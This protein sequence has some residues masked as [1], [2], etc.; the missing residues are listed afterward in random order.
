MRS[1]LRSVAAQ[2]AL[3]LWLP[4]VLLALHRTLL[5]E[6][7]EE[8]G[9]FDFTPPAKPPPRGL[10]VHE[11]EFLQDVEEEIRRCSRLARIRLR[12]ARSLGVFALVSTATIPITVAANLPGWIA[13]AL[14]SAATVAQGVQQIRSDQ[15][16]AVESHLL[17]VDLNRAARKY[18]LSV[19]RYPGVKRD[20]LFDT[21]VQGVDEIHSQARSRILE[22]MIATPSSGD[23]PMTEDREHS[24]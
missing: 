19:L 22:I 12:I 23:A 11:R 10:R 4:L 9:D 20:E 15:R 7:E 18:R 6:E 5:L 14:A 16:L 1:M 17:A 8:E 2:M 3:Y 21:F 24:D 13:V